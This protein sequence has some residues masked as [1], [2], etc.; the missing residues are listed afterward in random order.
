MATA[1]SPRVRSVKLGNGYYASPTGLRVGSK[2]KVVKD[3][4]LLSSLEKGT[5]RKV[6]KALRANGLAA[7]AGTPRITI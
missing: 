6:R 2:G 1:T 3:G 7:R 5:A 4:L